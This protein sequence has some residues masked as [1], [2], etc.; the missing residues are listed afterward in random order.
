VTQDEEDLTLAAQAAV[1]TMVARVE[2]DAVLVRF[3]VLAEIIGA[4]SDRAV[5]MATGPDQRVWDTLGL[6]EYAR[7]IDYAAVA[8]DMDDD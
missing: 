6:L 1:A 5:W 2:P 8:A 7:A 3:V 4:D